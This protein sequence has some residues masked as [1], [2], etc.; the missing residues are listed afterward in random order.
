MSQNVRA[1]T[2]ARPS[3]PDDRARRWA[4]ASAGDA[5]RVTQVRP[6]RRRRSRGRERP[7]RWDDEPGW[8]RIAG[9]PVSYDYSAEEI[10]AG[11]DRWSTWDQ[12][13]P[14]ERG[15]RRTR[16]GWSPSSAR[17]TTSSGVLKTGKEADVF[18]LRARR[19]RHRPGC[20]LAAKRYRGDAAPQFHRDAGYLEGRRVRKTRDNRAIA[21][22][23][24][25]GRQ[26]IAGQWAGAE[27]DALCRL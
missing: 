9:L 16:T 20:L 18:L 12:S 14:T 27:F 10:P 7:A 26:L 25:F 8:T 17:S 2:A 11:A 24:A 23:G 13:Q 5:H 1:L 4:T 19:A 21:N 6:P 3:P 15:P 22:R